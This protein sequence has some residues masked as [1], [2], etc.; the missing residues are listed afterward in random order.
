MQKTLEAIFE[1]GVL[2]PVEPLT[3]LSEKE[4]VIIAVTL[5]DIPHPLAGWIGGMSADEAEE[6]TQIIESAFEQV[7]ADEW[8]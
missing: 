6:M 8:R 4:K 7:N 2:K 3:W 1:N 5:P